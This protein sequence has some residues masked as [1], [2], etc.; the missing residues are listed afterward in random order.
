MTKCTLIASLIVGVTPLFCQ[1][2]WTEDSTESL[3][4]VSLGTG[5]GINYEFAIA[6]QLTLNVGAGLEVASYE[7]N[8]RQELSLTLVGNAEPRWYYNLFSRRDASLNTK[9]NA[10]NFFAVKANAVPLYIAGGENG[11]DQVEN[12]IALIP[13]YGLRRNLSD[14][15]FIDVSAGYGW[16]WGNA[17]I[18][19]AVILIDLRFGLGL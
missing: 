6:P 15:W 5:V 7:V 8:G 9:N 16:Y 3:G 12:A 18:N 4:Y 2:Q 11:T 10:A 17:G 14:F 19:G 13:K 1:G